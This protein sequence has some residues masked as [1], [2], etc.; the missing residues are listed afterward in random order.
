MTSCYCLGLFS[1]IVFKLFTLQAALEERSKCGLFLVGTTVLRH[2]Y[3]FYMSCFQL[4]VGGTGTSD[5]PTVEFP[6]AYVATDPGILISKR[7][8]P[9]FFSEAFSKA[10]FFA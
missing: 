10:D 2:N 4:Q 9:F 8:P 3:R 7:P 5:P 1:D 6:G